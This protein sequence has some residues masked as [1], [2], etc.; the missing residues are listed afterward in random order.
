MHWVCTVCGYVHDDDAPPAICPVCGA[1]GDKF[2]EI[3]ED[4]PGGIDTSFDE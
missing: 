1:P 2:D 4:E 3:L